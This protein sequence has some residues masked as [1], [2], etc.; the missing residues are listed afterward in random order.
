[1]NKQITKRY[2]ILPFV[3][4][5]V[6]S[7][8]IYMGSRLVPAPRITAYNK[9]SDVLDYIQQEYVDTLSRDNLVD[10]SIE[11]MLEQLDPHSSY[12]P[13]ENLKHANEPLEGN[14]EG[15]GIEFHIQQ[16][17]I[18]VVAAISGGPS[19]QVGILPGDRI[20]KVDGKPVTGP[21]IS[22]DVVL[23][24]L[25][26]KG[27]TL[28]TVTIFRRGNE[29]PLDFKIVRGKIPIYSVDFSYM[30]DART[31]YIKISRFAATTYDEFM[32]ALLE[33]KEKGMK[34]LILDLRGNPGG[35]LDA[36]TKISDEFLGGRKM[37]V[38]TEG[39]ARPKSTYYA[40]QPGE[41]EEGK[42]VVLIDEGSASASEIVSGALQD[43]DRATIIG[44]RSFGKGL[45]QEQTVFPDGSALRLTIA[46][47]FTPTGRSIQ[48]SYV[49]GVQEYED[50]V[51][52]RY[53]RGE[54][55]SKDSIHMIDSLKFT[56]PGGKTVYGG[57]G[58]MPDIFVPLDTIY[59]SDYLDRLFA[60]GLPSQF[61]YDYVD[62]N[63]E[64][65]TAFTN[66]SSYR[67]SF[68]VDDELLRE[69]VAYAS[70]KGV[71]LVEEQLE[72]SA[73]LIR[74]QLKAYIGRLIWK[75]E[76]LFP[77]LH[78]A[79]ATFQKALDVLNNNI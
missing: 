50:E 41:F 76:G 33:L 62:K 35:Y 14:F 48:K 61:A 16:D 52:Q 6:L 26:G 5:F 24:S 25:R 31:G 1:M 68:N 59:E 3:L 67:R 13:A 65:F 21:S 18:M 49:N 19:E 15:I 77:I 44:R 36:A 23:K 47:Y 17:S 39:K 72:R 30:I 29:K 2:I 51:L 28:V 71:P 60:M 34:Q 46:R 11:K 45:V 56:T 4:G 78:E 43:W 8:G 70:G 10:R 75:N 38:Y 32:N 73:P 63:R 40:N 7:G 42:L 54:L 53:K 69:F 12:I 66:A 64:Q 27:G 55:L 58:I 37:I 9:I 20:I 22:N 57:G 74:I 79:D